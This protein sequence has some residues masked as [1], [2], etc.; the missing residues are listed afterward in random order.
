MLRITG[1]ACIGVILC[2]FAVAQ[3][4]DSATEQAVIAI[5][6]EMLAAVLKGDTSASEKYLADSYVF[7]APQGFTMTKADSI[8]V[9]KS[10]DLKLE[11]ATLEDAKVSV[12]GNAAI[13]TYVSTDK[14][15]FKGMDISGRTRWTDVFVKEKG[16]WQMVASHGSAAMEPPK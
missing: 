6:K 3:K 1:A 9:L 11:S 15:T 14:G 10:G 16:R 4:K 7:T 5:E 2:A 12:Y 13:V 8:A